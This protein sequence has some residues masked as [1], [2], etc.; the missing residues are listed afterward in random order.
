MEEK[1]LDEK[2]LTKIPDY[3]DRNSNNEYE[4]II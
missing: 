3:D 2:K 4:A 1:N